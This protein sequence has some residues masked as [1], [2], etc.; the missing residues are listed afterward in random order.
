VP[1]CL[2]FHIMSTCNRVHLT[3]ADGK[4]ILVNDTV[5]HLT[6]CLCAM[7]GLPPPCIDLSCPRTS[8]ETKH[9]TYTTSTAV[10][11]RYNCPNHLTNH[12]PLQGRLFQSITISTSLGSIQP[13]CLHFHLFITV[14]SH[15]QLRQCGMEEM[16]HRSSLIRI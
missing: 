4:R 16:E 12:P 11:D 3:D 1:G 10:P 6:G 5:S 7:A 13:C 15:I 14:C 2:L 8:E 9:L